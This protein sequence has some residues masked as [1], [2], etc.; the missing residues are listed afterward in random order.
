VS[1]DT[2]RIA[3]HRHEPAGGDIWIVEPSGSE[4]RLTWDAA[5]HNSSPVWSPDGRDIVF[6]SQRSGKSGLYRKRSDGSGVDELLSESELPKAPLSWS[7]D[8]LSIVFSTQDP[9]TKGD[10][11]LLSVAD[12]KPM[13]LVNSPANERWRLA[14]VAE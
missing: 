1:P 6:A 11:W 7:A 13:P 10:L 8:G 9:K 12:K 4:T 2:K 3:V 5:Q 14:A